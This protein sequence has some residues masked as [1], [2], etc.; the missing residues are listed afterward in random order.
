[1]SKTGLTL[2]GLYLAL[3]A[4]CFAFAFSA[5]GDPKG[6]FVFLQLP[7]APQLTAAQVLGLKSDMGWISAYALIAVPT[8]ALLYALGDLLGRGLAALTRQ[9]GPA[10]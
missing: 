5:D 9:R 6:R 1:M 2:A 4:T 7:I 8:L 10:R 3:I